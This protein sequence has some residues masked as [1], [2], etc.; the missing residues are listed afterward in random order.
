MRKQH[1]KLILA[2]C[3]FLLV[4]GAVANAEDKKPKAE[5]PIKPAEVKLDRPVDFDKDILPILE[6]KC[7]SC[8]NL[9]DAENDL[10]LEE[11]GDILKG[12]K[13][14]P[15]VVA[16]DPEKSLLYTVAA[17]TADPAMP[18]LPNSVEAE[19]LTPEELG[20]LRQWILEG[21]NAGS[22]SGSETIQ[23]RPLPAGLNPIYAVA[24]STDSQ[25]VACGR[26]NRIVVYHIPSGKEV[27]QLTDSALLDVK[28]EDKPMYGPGVS[29][30]DFVHSLA[31]NEDATL[32]AS[33]GYRT[34]K[35]WQRQ[36]DIVKLNIAAEGVSAI[37]VS[38][39]GKWLATGGAGN[40]IKLFNLADGK[41]GATLAGPTAGI[42]EVRFSADSAKVYAS[43][44]DKTVRIWNLAD[45]AAA[46]H[47]TSPAAINGFTFSKD[48]KQIITAD[49]D[50]TIR[51]WPVPTDPAVAVTAAAKEIKGHGKPVTAVALISPAGTQLLSGSEDGTVRVWNLAD[52]KQVRSMAHGAPVTAVAVRPDGQRFASAGGTVSKLWNPA[53]GKQIAEVKG[54]VRTGNVVARRTDDQTIAKALLTVARKAVE[55]GDK[56]LKAATEA[57]GKAKTAATEAAKKAVAATEAAKKPAAAKAVND[58]KVADAQAAEKAAQETQKATNK[59]ATDTAAALKTATENAAKAKAAADKDK[60]NKDLAA[61]KVAADKA[62]ADA[63]KAA[64]DATAKK[65]ATDKTVVAATAAVKAAQAEQA[66]TDKAA[67]PLTDAANKANAAK[68]AADKALVA[69]EKASKRATSTL[70]T[71]NADKTAKEAVHKQATDALTVANT[72]STG[73]IKPIKTLAFSVDN[74]FLITAGDDNA[75]HTWDAT[76]GAGLESYHG[77]KGAIQAVAV[78]PAGDIVSASAD[79]TIKV[80]DRNPAWKLIARL[81]TSQDDPLDVSQSPFVNR[82]L[83]LDFSDDGSKLVTGGGDPSRS[84]ELLIWDVAKQ[85]LE[86]TFTDAHSDTIFGVEFSRNGKHL[87]SGAA[88]KFAKIFDV[89]TGKHVKSFEGHTHHVLDVS[90]RADGTVV[91]SAGADNAIKVW[92]VASGEQQ[93]TIG[94]YAKQVTSLHFIGIGSNIVSCGGDKTV[95][96][97]KTGDGKNFRSFAGGTDYMYSAGAARDEKLVIAGGEDGVLRIWNG[98]DGKVIKTFDPPQNTVENAQAKK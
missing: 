21:A 57:Q 43:S 13:R 23:W 31:F 58:K 48:A 52:G 40:T 34:V 29:H 76:T 89:A 70:A 3:G 26:A 51:L 84:G 27:S 90:W 98:T 71:A 53:D 60:D 95:R 25:Y 41:P 78:T 65:A 73:H 19:V 61:A 16:K 18:P 91:A 94:G 22:G 80:W 11:V 79:N 33:G 6:E 46:G 59:A 38:P 30:R 83:A 97:H 64:D 44:L 68:T 10:S 32:L 39:D 37:T 67:K 72:A 92:N 35:L 24:V 74:S 81:G 7:I 88:D 12:G 42:T 14:G 55:N 82:V 5:K 85:S 45:G 56:A 62:A 63:K 8:H 93:R 20:L 50:N 36:R 77:H 86:R 66:V 49:A 4:C 87:L 96:F 28:Y 69:A 75:V 15:S 17:R 9:A 2:A 1:G 47:I 54:E